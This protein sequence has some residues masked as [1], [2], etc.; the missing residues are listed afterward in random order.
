MCALCIGVSAA[1]I[2]H[3]SFGCFPTC[4][5]LGAA[6]LITG[7][8]LVIALQTYPAPTGSSSGGHRRLL[9]R[10]LLG[11]SSSGGELTLSQSLQ[12]GEDGVMPASVGDLG[13]RGGRGGRELGARMRLQVAQLCV[14]QPALARNGQSMSRLIVTSHPSLHPNR[15]RVGGRVQA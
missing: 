8:D 1:G 6:F 9:H 4:R 2:T 5:A 11:G 10:R 7:T 13:G 3:Q 14:T 12:P 15:E